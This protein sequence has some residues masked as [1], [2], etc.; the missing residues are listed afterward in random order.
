M[1]ANSYSD[2]MS[3]IDLLSYIY[4]VLFYVIFDSNKP[5]H[6]MNVLLKFYV[7]HVL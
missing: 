1:S 2:A 6:K 3:I 7:N 4:S 5:N